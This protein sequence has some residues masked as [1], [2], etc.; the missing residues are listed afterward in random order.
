MFLMRGVIYARAKQII[1]QPCLGLAVIFRL[2][3]TTRDLLRRASRGVRGGG[4]DRATTWRLALPGT[5]R[6]KPK[7]NLPRSCERRLSGALVVVLPAGP[8]AA[9]ASVPAKPSGARMTCCTEEDGNHDIWGRQ[10][11]CQER[12]VK[13]GRPPDDPSI[14]NPR[15]DPPVGDLMYGAAK[16]HKDIDARMHRIKLCAVGRISSTS[17]EGAQL[18]CRRWRSLTGIGRSLT[19]SAQFDVDNTKI[20]VP[21]ALGNT[22][23]VVW[24][25][26]LHQIDEGRGRQE[27]CQKMCR[28]EGGLF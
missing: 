9:C 15:G 27:G 3:S 5:A 11:G 10:A 26:T 28:Q 8:G 13:G 18:L 25:R 7:P 16:R 21:M 2:R 19:Q 17:D 6:D 23:R 24:S 4:R 1:A 22:P 14:D 20:E 12:A